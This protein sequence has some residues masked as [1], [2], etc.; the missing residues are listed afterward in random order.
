MALVFKITNGTQLVRY[1]I[2]IN[3]SRIRNL[4]MKLRNESVLKN[5]EYKAT[6]IKEVETLQEAKNFV[7]ELK[8]AIRD[9]EAIEKAKTSEPS[10]RIWPKKGPNGEKM[11]GTDAW[12]IDGP[13]EPNVEFVFNHKTNTY[14]LVRLWTL[15]NYS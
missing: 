6:L 7:Y 5:A 4:E 12:I 3:R 15:P 11:R 13:Q 14:E 8:K 10:R 2:C 1:S 9:V